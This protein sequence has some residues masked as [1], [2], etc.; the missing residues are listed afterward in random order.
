MPLL[1]QTDFSIQKQCIPDLK[2][3]RPKYQ[4]Y[5][6]KLVDVTKYCEIHK[7]IF[8]KTKGRNVLKMVQ[9]YIDLF[10]VA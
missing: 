1:P 8:H 4:E 5:L 3:P 6:F 7:N 9:C 10:F 2:D